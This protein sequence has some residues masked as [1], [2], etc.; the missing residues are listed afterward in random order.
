MFL[1]GVYQGQLSSLD[2]YGKPGSQKTSFDFICSSW[3]YPSLKIFC[4]LPQFHGGER[5]A[6]L[7][8]SKARFE[9]QKSNICFQEQRPYYSNLTVKSIDLY[10]SKQII[11]MMPQSRKLFISTHIQV[12]S[13]FD[14][15]FKTL[16]I[17]TPS[18]TS[19]FVSTS[20]STATSPYFSGYISVVF[21]C[22]PP[23]LHSVLVL[24][25][26]SSTATIATSISV[27]FQL[28][29]QLLTLLQL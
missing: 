28:P 6:C 16:S 2:A 22:L 21:S 3:R 29:L 23:P 18:N 19:S 17:Y 13:A 24:S 25:F 9:R 10:S 20:I 26:V 11:P 12:Y 5:N 8:C 7:W 1:C 15:T 14:S 4:L 27:L